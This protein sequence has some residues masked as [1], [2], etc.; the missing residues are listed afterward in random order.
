[1]NRSNKISVSLIFVIAIICLLTGCMSNGD[2]AYYHDDHLFFS[3]IKVGMSRD[4]AAA[5]VKDSGWFNDSIESIDVTV[6]SCL[7]DVSRYLENKDTL[8]PV[9]SFSGGK[10][11]AVGAYINIYD[12]EKADESFNTYYEKFISMYDLSNFEETVSDTCY[13][14]PYSGRSGHTIEI[15]TD[16]T[17]LNNGYVMRDE[18]Y[19]FR[20]DEADSIGY[21]FFKMFY[22]H[23]ENPDKNPN[24]YRLGCVMFDTE[25]Q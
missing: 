3:G 24:I 6:D 18:S 16:Q 2:E 7:T 12:G 8:I 17:L 14:E 19:H 11:N 23:Q 5:S 21:G 9:V 1:M 13:I 25:Q 20:I 4:E 15:S 22:T 10:V